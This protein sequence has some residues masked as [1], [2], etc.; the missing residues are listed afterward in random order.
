[1]M[2]TTDHFDL[3]LLPDG[4]PSGELDNGE[5]P[6]DHL[7]RAVR[8]AQG[9]ATP[10]QIKTA[11]LLMV[12]PRLSA[13]NDARERL[14]S[15]GIADALTCSPSTV[16]EALWAAREALGLVPRA[17]GPMSPVQLVYPHLFALALRSAAAKYGKPQASG[18]FYWSPAATGL[19]AAPP[20]QSLS[21]RAV[22]PAG[23]ILF[24]LIAE[25][26]TLRWATL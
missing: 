22:M 6:A 9:W 5:A 7:T 12:D 16:R 24:R 10:L 2:T 13:L 21:P 23:R 1:M 19:W 26:D 15:A 14:V 3:P 11:E 25:G 18:R 17:R 20:L 8:L 4:I